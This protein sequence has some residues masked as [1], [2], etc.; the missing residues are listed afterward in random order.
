MAKTVLKQA[1][2]AL[3]SNDLSGY[4]SKIELKVEADEQETTTFGSSG[5]KE[6]LGGINSGSLD[7]TFK[8]DVAASAIDSILW[9]LLGTVVTFEVRLSNASVGASNPKYTGS[10]L[11]KEYSPIAG[12]VGDVA[13]FDVSYPTTGAITRATS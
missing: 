1:Y 12:G 3:N 9:P 11:I 4:C 8:Q 10:V 7:L 6:V 13:E 2:V 5:W